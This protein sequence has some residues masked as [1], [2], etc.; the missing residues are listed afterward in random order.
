M[1]LPS[2]AAVATG[3]TTAVMVYAIHQ[4]STP[5]MAEMRVS[6]AGDPDLDAA[7]RQATWISA[8][9]VA[10][11][12]LIV[13]DPTVFIIGGSTVVAMDWWTRYSNEVMPE[14]GKATVRSRTPDPTAMAVDPT[15]LD[16]PVPA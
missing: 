8:A 3:L 1:A 11:I 14:T 9:I 10:G 2:E 13:R 12:S 7:R 5:T 16:A 4:Q 15:N 6:P